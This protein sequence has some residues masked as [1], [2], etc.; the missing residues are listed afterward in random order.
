[1]KRVGSEAVDEVQS[2]VR[3]LQGRVRKKYI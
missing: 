3:Q 1:M 2:C